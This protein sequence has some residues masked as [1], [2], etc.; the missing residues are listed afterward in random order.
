MKSPRKRD[1]IATYIARFIAF[2]IGISLLVIFVVLNF[3]QTAS[4]ESWMIFGAMTGLCIGYGLGGDIWGAK[5]FDLFT[6]L[7][8]SKA[9][10]A[11]K[12]DDRHTK[13]LSKATLAIAIGFLVFF[14]AI[15]ILAF[16]NRGST[17]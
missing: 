13:F 12:K 8:T 5:L 9:V 3:K 6:H 1:K 11:D 17:H 2:C 10:E 15:L 4:F 14:S 16:L 7:N